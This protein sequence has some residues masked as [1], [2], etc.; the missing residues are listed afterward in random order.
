MLALPLPRRSANLGHT[1]VAH[2]TFDNSTSTFLH[3]GWIH[4]PTAT[5]STYTYWG[6]VHTTPPMPWQE[7][8]RRSFFGTSSM[9]AMINA[10]Q[11][12]AVL[13]GSF[14]FSAWVKPR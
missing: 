5:T 3:W 7:A 4:R 10:D 6:P 11:S 14:T 2:Y 9:D 12:D 1:N 13:A 8:A